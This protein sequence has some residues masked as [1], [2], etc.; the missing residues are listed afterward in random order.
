MLKEHRYI[1]GS[2]RWSRSLRRLIPAAVSLMLIVGPSHADDAYPNSPI[3][4]VIPSPP[5]GMD[6]AGLRLVSLRIALAV[7]GM[8]PAVAACAG[9]PFQDNESS[10]QVAAGRPPDHV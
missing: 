6:W 9:G 1:L 7:V 8:I 10:N 4:M 5:G 2:L 3:R